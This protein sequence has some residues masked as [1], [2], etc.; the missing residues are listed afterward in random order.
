MQNNWLN[1]KIIN[2]DLDELMS[3]TLE[4]IESRVVEIDLKSIIEPNLKHL[5][6]PY[7]LE[8]NYRNH[9]KLFDIH[10]APGCMLTGHLNDC[11]YPTYISL[12]VKISH[13][14]Y[15][16]ET[17]SPINLP[18]GDWTFYIPFLEKLVTRVNELKEKYDYRAKTVMKSSMLGLSLVKPYINKIGLENVTLEVAENMGVIMKMQIVNNTSLR[19]LLTID[20]YKQ[21]CDDFVSIAKSLHVFTM[22]GIRRGVELECCGFGDDI[23]SRNNGPWRAC[24]VKMTYLDVFP[25]YGDFS[26]DKKRIGATIYKCLSDLGYIFYVENDNLHVVLNN[27]ISLIRSLSTKYTYFSYE[28]KTLEGRKMKV[29]DKTFVHLLQMTAAASV[30]TG[31]DFDVKS[32][33][34]YYTDIPFLDNLYFYFERLL[35]YNT[36]WN[37]VHTGSGEYWTNDRAYYHNGGVFHVMLAPDCYI[38]IRPTGGDTIDVIWEVMENWNEI[39]KIKDIQRDYPKYQFYLDDKDKEFSFNPT[40]V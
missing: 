6:Y 16:G 12:Q 17:E 39:L 11:D 21:H 4:L 36:S 13:G 30:K 18:I 33:C 15:F 28:K 7:T 24:D 34:H 23:M 29:K 38:K 25:E 37:N 35:P 8:S 19:T 2:Q 14:E 1:S 32:T 10:V 20:N 5:G 31:Y 3:S 9:S 26:Q 22:P 27:D 40:E